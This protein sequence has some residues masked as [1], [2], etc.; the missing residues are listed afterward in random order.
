MGFQQYQEP[1][2]EL[3]QELRTFAR[4]IAS[5]IEEAD[6]INWYEQRMSVEKDRQA[7]SV[8]LAAQEEEFKIFWNG[9]GIPASQKAE[10]ESCPPIYFISRRRD[11][12]SRR[13]RRKSRTKSNRGRKVKRMDAGY[14][15]QKLDQL[16]MFRSIAG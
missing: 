5:L 15:L 11:C 3:T 10:V 9:P 2:N 8:M 13:P 4:M 14:K 1:A 12:G 6:A 7:I 16:S